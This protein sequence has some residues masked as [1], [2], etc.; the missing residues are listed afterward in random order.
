MTAATPAGAVLSPFVA[1]LAAATR[2]RLLAVLDLGDRLLGAS[3]GPRSAGSGDWLAEIVVRLPSGKQLP[4]RVDAADPARPALFRTRHLALSYTSGTV[5]PFADAADAAF[6]NSLRERIDRADSP[7]NPSVTIAEF[8]AALSRY[9]PFLPVKDEDYRLLFGAGAEPVG[10]LWLGFGC[11]QDCRMCWQ[12]RDWPAPPDEV[13]EHWIDQLCAAGVSGIVLSGGEPTRHP[14]LADWIARARAARTHV[15]VET[16]G[17][18]LAEPGYLDGLRAAGVGD[19]VVSLHAADASLSDSMTATAGGFARTVAGL[20]CALDAGVPVG[21]HCVVERANVASL[22][23]HAR[24]VASELRSGGRGVRRVSYSFPIA[25]YRRELY[26]DAIPPLDDLRPHLSA[27]VRHLRAAGIEARFLGMSGFPVCAVES[28][29]EEL[30]LLP[31]S[32]ADDQRVD[33]RFVD[34]CVDCAVRPRC[35]GVHH[36]YVQAHGGRGVVAVRPRNTSR[37]VARP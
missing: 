37:A 27:A 36:T 16:N 25:Y 12:G 5:D 29:E 20:R 33:R 7:G 21:I 3:L 35:L 14:R 18:R 32:V 2:D 24:F 34:P 10:L 28:P 23:D 30:H 17:M 4:L 26:R 1:P 11:D 8:L 15:T 19:I 13:F 22:A 31:V 9:R 6:L